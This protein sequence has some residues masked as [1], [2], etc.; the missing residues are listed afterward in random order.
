MLEALDGDVA[1]SRA[2]A[3][4]AAPV[5]GRTVGVS[6]EEGKD[7]EEEE[8]DSDGEPVP[9]RS[10]KRPLPAS[11]EEESPKRSTW[12]PSAADEGSAWSRLCNMPHTTQPLSRC[13]F[14][15]LSPSL[16]LFRVHYGAFKRQ[17][18]RLAV[19]RYF[20]ETVR[21]HASSVI[22]VH[23][24]YSDRACALSPPQVGPQASHVPD[25]IMELALESGNQANTGFVRP[26]DV[27][28]PTAT[29]AKTHTPRP[30]PAPNTHLLPPRSLPV[31]LLRSRVC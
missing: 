6:Q 30:A 13:T 11:G 16:A 17:M 18:L 25:A 15:T 20:A 22:V 23:V 28:A 31:L 24:L 14:P 19:R 9:G 8:L 2:A 26:E 21:G 29:H 7:G 12:G 3:A 4:A 1:G 10:R 27:R 5:G